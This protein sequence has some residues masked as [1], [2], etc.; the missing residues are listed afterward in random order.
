MMTADSE[1]LFASWPWPGKEVISPRILPIS[2]SRQHSGARSAS[3]VIAIT[4]NAQVE[5]DTRF[6][7]ICEHLDPPTCR[8]ITGLS[9]SAQSALRVRH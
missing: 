7:R 5:R 1:W 9:I 2:P 8:H 6:C 3:I 4:N